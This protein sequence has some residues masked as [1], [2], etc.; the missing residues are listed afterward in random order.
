M[1][2]HPP[3]CAVDENA[4]TSP[5]RVTCCR[6]G[7][8]A[9]RPA[10]RRATKPV[11]ARLRA[12]LLRG[13]GGALVG[14]PLATPGLARDRSFREGHRGDPRRH[15]GRDERGR[16]RHG[17]RATGA[18]RIAA[19]AYLRHARDCGRAGRRRSL[20]RVSR[21]RAAR[22]CHLRDAPRARSHRAP[23]CDP[24]P[25]RAGDAGDGRDD[26]G[27]RPARAVR[28]LVDCEPLRDEHGGRRGRRPVRELRRA[29]LLRCGAQRDRAGLRQ[30]ERRRGLVALSLE[31][32]RRD[33]DACDH[34][35]RSR[36]AK[37]SRRMPY[38]SRRCSSSCPVSSRSASRWL[39]F[40]RSAPRF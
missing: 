10:E 19:A 21:D 2:R 4:H 8:D 6:D 22:R 28:A 31:S 5:G 20:A 12:R 30:P 27:L 9:G 29:A 25:A 26:S 40:V 34:N 39:G 7:G 14:G 37:R 38:V 18:R 3:S 24:R 17:A 13:R 36:R 16:G 33:A 15:D 11:R 23:C 35:D 1:T 32:A